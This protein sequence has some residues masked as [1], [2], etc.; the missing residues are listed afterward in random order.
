MSNNTF[1][2]PKTD[3]KCIYDA[4]GSYIGDYFEPMDYNRIK[5]NINFLKDM[6]KELYDNAPEFTDLGED[7]N[8]G[9]PERWRASW[10]TSLQ[11]NLE[12]INLCSAKLIIGE[13]ENYRSNAAGK[14]VDELNR[15]EKATLD[16][17]QRL[18]I[19]KKSKKRLS[20]RLGGAKGVV[21]C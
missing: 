19:V 15:I 11:D 2:T 17:F 8:Y 10:W 12:Q 4:S 14:L 21:K 9:S 18:K 16:I 3:W 13:R 5:N 7:R 20:T 1:I 6:A